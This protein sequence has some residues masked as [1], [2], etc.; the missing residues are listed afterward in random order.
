PHILRNE[1]KAMIQMWRNPDDQPVI[2]GAAH[3]CWA[4]LYEF[5][6][7]EPACADGILHEG[8]VDINRNPNLTFKVFRE[9]FAA[10]DQP[11]EREY[12]CWILNDLPIQAS[13]AEPVSLASL[14]D[15]PAQQ[16]AWNLMI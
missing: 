9:S 7:G 5:S 6:R 16:N 15:S 1:V 10:L 3:W 13:H 4:D 12:R 2:T 14:T 11:E 8:L